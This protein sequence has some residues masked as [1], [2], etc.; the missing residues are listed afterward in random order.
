M[1]VFLRLIVFFYFA[2]HS[3]VSNGQGDCSLRKDQNGIKVFICKTENTKL[4]LIRAIFDLQVSSAELVNLIKDA[5]GYDHWQYNTVNAHL[6]ET[7]SDKELI[8]YAEVVAPWPISNRDLVV[9]LK[10]ER[11]SL[12]KNTIVTANG[13][14]DYI[15]GKKGIVRVPMSKSKWIIRPITESSVSVEYTMLIDPGGSV[16]LW[17]VNMVAE[18]AP[19][20]SF[21]DLKKMVELH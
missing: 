9:R 20:K 7:I 10:V 18:E 2:L 21:R 11:D 1:N 3:H 16:P 14:P 8:Y 19:Y 6:V 13:V 4:K 12:S 17:M 15:P 5:A